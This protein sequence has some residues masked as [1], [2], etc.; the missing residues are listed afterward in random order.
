MGEERREIGGG[1]R[2]I[3]RKRVGRG[4]KKEEKEKTEKREMGERER[5]QRERDR[6]TERE[7]ERE[8]EREGETREIYRGQ[9]VSSSTSCQFVKA[10][11][12]GKTLSCLYKD[13]T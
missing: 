11:L 3:E 2:K 5:R 12:K 9:E 8:R 1:E 13:I 10:P 4:K 7:R 6:E